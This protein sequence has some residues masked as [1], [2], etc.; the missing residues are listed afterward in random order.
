MP[1]DVDHIVAT[2]DPE[3]VG[4]EDDRLPVF[5]I[6]SGEILAGNF[7]LDV[8]RW[9]SEW[10]DGAAKIY[11]IPF[12]HSVAT[13]GQLEVTVEPLDNNAPAVVQTFDQIA[14]SGAGIFWPGGTK[15]PPTW[16]LPTHRHG[17]GTLGLLR[18]DS[19]KTSGIGHTH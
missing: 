8:N 12:D 16:S 18:T 11:W 1:V 19:V 15:F 3:M 10:P 13:T 14:S 9:S 17:A 5:D 4:P 7:A 6:R 2:E